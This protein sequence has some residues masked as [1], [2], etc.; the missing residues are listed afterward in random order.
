MG[1]LKFFRDYTGLSLEENF[2]LIWGEF[3]RERAEQTANDV[4]K[5]WIDEEN[6]SQEQIEK[7]KKLIAKYI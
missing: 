4:M 3:T 1:F 5:I 7:A 6:P 2:R